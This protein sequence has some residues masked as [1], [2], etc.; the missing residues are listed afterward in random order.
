[1]TRPFCKTIQVPFKRF[2]PIK[3]TKQTLLES[4]LLK[5]KKPIIE[6]DEVENTTIIYKQL[7]HKI[8]IICNFQNPPKLYNCR[9]QLNLIK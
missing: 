3:A 5:F 9:H 2:N 7:G 4:L 1:M 8:F 6:V